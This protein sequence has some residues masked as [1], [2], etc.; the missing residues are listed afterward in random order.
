M[1]AVK[2]KRGEKPK[3]RKAKAEVVQREAQPRLS[4]M[5]RRALMLGVPL[6]AMATLALAGWAYD[7]PG[8]ARAALA[9]GSA[10][11]GLEIR[12]VE[13]RGLEQVPRLA[14]YEAVLAG[15]SNPMLATDLAAIRMR[16]RAMPWVA[17]ASVSRR[18]P[19]TVVVDVRER[20]PVALW[21]NDGRF[22]LIDITGRVLASDGLDEFA[23]LPLVVGDGA[24]AQVAGLLDLA[25]AAPALAGKVH[26]AILVG[27]RRWNLRF[28]TG[29]TL[30][31]PDTPERARAALTRFAALEASLPEGRKLLG[32]QF[33]RF[34]L[35]LPGQMVVGGEEVAKAI[36]AARKA[37]DEAKRATI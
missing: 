35:R 28:K 22:H 16:L 4:A 6:T 21:Q 3:Q 31:L 15:P 34:D 14:V 37:A 8:N 20:K 10:A 19:D 33:E 12:H 7:W 24:N 32:G 25:D 17:D 26:A 13:V 9:L 5:Q 1:G 36:E 23:A 30:M 2:T 11:A 29:E 18:L 27:Q